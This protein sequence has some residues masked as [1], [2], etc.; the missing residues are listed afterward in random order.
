MYDIWL[1]ENW[2]TWE[3]IHTSDIWGVVSVGVQPSVLFLDICILV[4]WMICQTSP[5]ASSC[6][7]SFCSCDLVIA[8]NLSSSLLIL[9]WSWSSLLLTPL[10]WIFQFRI[11]V[12]CFSFVL[13]FFTVSTSLLIF[14]SYLYTIF[15]ISFSC[16]NS[17]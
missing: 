3:K 9:S 15:L 13:F 1:S 16:L 7:L 14:S 2:L 12:F 6:F 8:N 17:L 4:C 5:R 10:H 11:T